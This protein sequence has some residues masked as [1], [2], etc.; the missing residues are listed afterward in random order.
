[1][2]KKN[3][4]LILVGGFTREYPSVFAPVYKSISNVLST[5]NLKVYIVPLTRRYKRSTIVALDPITSAYLSKLGVIHQSFKDY[6]SIALDVEAQEDAINYLRDFHENPILKKLSDYK[7]I[8]LWRANELDIWQSFFYRYFQRINLITSI[9]K[10]NSPSQVIIS[11]FSSYQNILKQIAEINSIDTVNRAPIHEKLTKIA[12]KS[13]LPIAVKLLKS[14]N[15]LRLRV[16]YQK[17]SMYEGKQKRILFLADYPPIGET[18]LNIINILGL[19]GKY[20]KFVSLTDMRKQSIKK[21]VAY[22][23][24]S[25]YI[26][27]E[28]V[29]RQND[30]KKILKMRFKDLQRFL[31]KKKSEYKGVNI[32]EVLTDLSYFLYFKRYPESAT[33]IELMEE[34]VRKENPDLFLLGDDMFYSWRI[35]TLVAKKFNIPTLVL[36]HG[37]LMDFSARGLYADNIAVYGRETK[38]ILIKRGVDRRRIYAIG[39]ANFD[40][41]YKKRFDDGANK[42]KLG[43]PNS[44]KII[45]FT[46]TGNDSDTE[47]IKL[48]MKSM[49]KLN[50]VYLIIKLHP[51]YYKSEKHYLSIIKENVKNILIIKNFNVSDII[52]LSDVMI[53]RKSTTALEAVVFNKPIIQIGQ[54]ETFGDHFYSNAGYVENGIAVP[55]KGENDLKEAIK[56]CI[57]N[58][59][60]RKIFST[61]RKKYIKDNLFKFD[62]KTVLRLNDCIDK[63][64]LQTSRK[65]K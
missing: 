42:V 3:R 39:N 40:V 30:T 24:I 41:L 14:K 53:T 35:T 51:N 9:V 31:Y 32:N 29:S 7:G 18:T 19:K 4:S 6:F 65:I 50:N 13:F 56:N 17:K 34:I 48:I 33:L 36:Q 54:N 5:F 12:Y 21:G 52:H 60:L 55:V 46:A 43:I 61:N 44:K 2:N 15:N 62:G 10:K 1:M 20:V 64:L 38:N 45:L 8:S 26:T 28:I 25:E 11:G 37:A 49:R 27:T 47:D 57:T 58:S 16:N 63:V 23:T 22:S 59:N